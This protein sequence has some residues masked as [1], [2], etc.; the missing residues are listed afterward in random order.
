MTAPERP[1]EGAL[2]PVPPIPPPAGL[3]HLAR[4]LLIPF[5][6]ALLALVG[7]LLVADAREIAAHLAGFDLALLAPVLG[8]SL[9]NYGLRFL[10]W[11]VYLRRLGVTLPRHR[12]LGV[13]LVGFLLSVTPGKAGEL[14]KAW[15][16][17]ELGGGR[18]LLVA[19]AVVAERATDVLGILS[20]V[21]LGA[22]AFPGGAWLTALGLAG[23]ATL[24]LLLTWRPGA[25]LAVRLLGRLPLVGARA[26]ALLDLHA[27]LASL[28]APRLLAFAL[29]LAMVAWGSEGVGFWLVVRHYAPATG[30]ATA[31]FD[32]TASSVV[33][34]LSLLPG[35]LLA[36]EGAMA[37]LL[38][39]HGIDT[40]AAASATIITRAATLWFAVLLGLIALPFVVRWV[41]GRAAAPPPSP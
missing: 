10:R 40:A 14:G 23:V 16:V 12:R 25:R 6:L 28:L 15:L 18:A 37:A 4:R 17:R 39:G 2:A 26:P 41:R 13:F 36:T 35:G 19:S 38:A 21:A 27:R 29:P 5:A 33:G 8:L 31:V 7:F 24:V 11:E 34:G 1:V 3:D 20:L 32:Y 9:V 22:L 30:L